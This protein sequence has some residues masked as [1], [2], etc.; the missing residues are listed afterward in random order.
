MADF[1]DGTNH[2]AIDGIVQD[3]AHERAVDLEEVD[4]EMLEVAERAQAGAEVVQRKTAPQ[5]AQRLDEAVRLAEAGHGRGL[6]DLEADLR[7]VDA[8]LLELFNDERQEL[9]VAQALAREVYRA[10]RELLALIRLADQPAQRV[11]DEP[12]IDR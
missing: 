11:L 7:R 12:A 3:L 8:A 5:L 2:L 9:V 6:G 10:H 1:I 4:R